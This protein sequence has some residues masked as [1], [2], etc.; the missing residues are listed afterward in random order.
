MRIVENKHTNEADMLIY[1]LDIKE[2][3]E[4]LRILAGVINS[5]AK[6]S[7]IDIEELELLV[8]YVKRDLYSSTPKK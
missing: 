1:Q 4:V 7:N 5:L 2:E 8:Y 6:S 3:P